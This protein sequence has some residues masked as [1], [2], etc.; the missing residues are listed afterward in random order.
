MPN[1]IFVHPL[2]DDERQTVVCGLRS[3]TAFTVRRCQIVL[4]SQR[5]ET[6]MAIARQLSCG[7]QTVRNVIHAFNT[8]GVAALR[9]GSTVAHRLPHTAFS[10]TS[11]EHLVSILNRSPRTFGKETSL[12]T[13]DL[14]AEVCFN[15]GLTTR[16]VSGETIRATLQRAGIRWKRAKHG[17]TSPDPAYTPKN[18]AATA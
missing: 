3:S 13:L 10:S 7:D 17:I 16:Q 8:I 4:A 2:T 6:P 9:K 18:T 11:I 14:L 12:W 15:E 5:G 1:P